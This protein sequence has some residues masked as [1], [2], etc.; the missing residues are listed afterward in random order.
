MRRGTAAE[1]LG[2]EGRRVSE[3][4]RVLHQNQRAASG[5]EHEGRGAWRP[6]RSSEDADRDRQRVAC[7][8]WGRGGG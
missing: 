6:R 7:G 8:A 4:D 1:V 3:E 2:G 5:S